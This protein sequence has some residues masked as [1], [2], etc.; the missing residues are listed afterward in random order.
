MRAAAILDTLRAHGGVVTVDGDALRVRRCKGMLTP[1]L[2]QLMA[3]EKAAMLALL[4]A[5]RAAREAPTRTDAVPCEACG[6]PE[7]WTWIDGR[8]ICRECLI[9]DRT[10]LIGPSRNHC[11]GCGSFDRELSPRGLIRC[12]RCGLV[13]VTEAQWE[14]LQERAAIMEFSGGMSREEAERT[15]LERL[16]DDHGCP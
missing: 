8:E 12:A 11:R 15:A 16:R 14:W 6:S 7:R 5:E 13:R 4:R 2:T 10:P 9:H 1:E 3:A